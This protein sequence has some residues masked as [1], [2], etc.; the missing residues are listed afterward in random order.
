MAQ[1]VEELE[2]EITDL[3]KEI[4]KLNSLCESLEF[5]EEQKAK[6]YEEVDKEITDLQTEQQQLEDLL[7]VLKLSKVDKKGGK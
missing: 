7:A 2:S 4:S 6:V 5:R 3:H 1:H